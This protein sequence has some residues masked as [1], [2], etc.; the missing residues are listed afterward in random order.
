MHTITIRLDD[1]DARDI[2]AALAFRQSLGYIPDATHDD[3]D[4]AGR[5]IA[6]ICRGWMERVSRDA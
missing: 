5:I 3:A 2:H 1:D 4:L 6:E